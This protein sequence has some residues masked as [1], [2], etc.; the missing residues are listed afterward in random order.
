MNLSGLVP[1]RTMRIAINDSG[2]LDLPPKPACINKKPF[3]KKSEKAICLDQKELIACNL[4]A[5]REAI[6]ALDLSTQKARFSPGFYS[7]LGY[8]SDEI[9]SQ[10]SSWY[11]MLHPD[12][13]RVFRWRLKIH[14]QQ[15][16]GTFHLKC[17]MKT[18]Q[19]KWKTVASCFQILFCDG[20]SVPLFLF[21]THT[22]VEASNNDQTWE[23]PTMKDVHKLQDTLLSSALSQSN[24][25]GNIVGK[26]RKMMQLY[27]RI[28]K[29]SQSNS[30]VVIHGESGT[31]KELAAKTIHELSHRHKKNFVTINCGA[32]PSELLESEFFGYKKGA[33]TGATIDRKGYLD[34][35]DG[36]TLFLDEV[37]ELNV[38]MQAKLLRAI[39]GGGYIPVGSQITIRPDIR[40]IA[41]TNHNLLENVRK[42]LMREDFFYRL[43]ILPIDMPP[44]RER[45][46]DLPILIDHFLRLYGEEN[47]VV[48]MPDQVMEKMLMYHWPGN[49]RELQNAIRRYITFAKIEFHPVDI[50]KQAN[51]FNIEIPNNQD[52]QSFLLNAEAYYI[53]YIL[54]AN[55]WHR[56]QTAK[57]LGI[58]RKT[59][60]KKIQ[61]HNLNDD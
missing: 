21:G 33:F 25:F 22:E 1:S 47:H 60:Y 16:P 53:K 5:T 23:D 30:N 58:N 41:A 59:L 61:R 13:L 11:A 43:H 35:A 44:L 49:V 26:S 57:I 27:S 37:A 56:G 40:I 19:N 8:K 29:V 2:R 6:S 39:D 54:A 20:N 42:G 36:G 4:K 51:V 17:R 32:I 24:R 52:L 31:G 14:Q 55:N 9:E 38:N 34:S 46:E 7:L 28:M 45:Y 10:M 3:P 12:S 48:D 18:K 15:S 50:I